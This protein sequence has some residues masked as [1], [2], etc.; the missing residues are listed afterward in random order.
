[1]IQGDSE[2]M[3]NQGRGGSILGM[4]DN[5]VRTCRHRPFVDIWSAAKCG[6]RAEMR[7]DVGP[8]F[9]STRKEK[10]L[11]VSNSCKMY[12]IDRHHF[13]RVCSMRLFT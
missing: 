4:I 13:P 12:S 8:D 10:G 1:M 6:S 3:D 7:H 2:W 9:G 5:P 11:L